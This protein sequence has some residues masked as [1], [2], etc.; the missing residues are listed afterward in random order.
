[1]DVAAE[2]RRGARRAL[3]AAIAAKAPEASVEDLAKLATA[4][5]QIVHGPQGGRMDYTYGYT[6]TYEHHE[7]QHPHELDRSGRGAGFTS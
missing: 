6:G 1:M 5:Q 3:L 2:E 4:F 7:H